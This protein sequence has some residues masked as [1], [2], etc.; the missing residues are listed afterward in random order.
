M[1]RGKGAV[2]AANESCGLI[3]DR[4]KRMTRRRK[5]EICW[6]GKGGRGNPSKGEWTIIVVNEGI[7]HYRRNC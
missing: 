5:M 3:K 6:T 4:K 2:M 7:F 1:V